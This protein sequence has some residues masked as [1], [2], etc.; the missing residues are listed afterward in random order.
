MGAPPLP[1][2]FII[3]NPPTKNIGDGMSPPSSCFFFPRLHTEYD[4]SS[5]STTT[6]SMQES[7]VYLLLSMVVPTYVEVVKI[8]N[9]YIFHCE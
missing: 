8:I 9:I 2:F 1:H 6:P 4:T 5:I 3:T 7:F